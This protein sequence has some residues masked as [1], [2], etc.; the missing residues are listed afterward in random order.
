MM[1]AAITNMLNIVFFWER[2]LVHVPAL[3][4]WDVLASME[5]ISMESF[6]ILVIIFPV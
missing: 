3:Q 6:L 5:A 4:N 2:M 1:A